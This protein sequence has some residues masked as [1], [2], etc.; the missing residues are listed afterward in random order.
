MS[1]MDQFIAAAAQ[2]FALARELGEEGINSI[3]WSFTYHGTAE[4]CEEI[5]ERMN[6][7]LVKSGGRLTI[8]VA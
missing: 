4:A 8:G 7:A 1:K 6:E 3:D 5:Q 2:M